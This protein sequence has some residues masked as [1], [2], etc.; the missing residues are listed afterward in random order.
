MIKMKRLIPLALFL[1]TGI[2]L[3]GQCDDLFFSEYVEGYS[4]NKALEI[5]NPT[6]EPINLSEYSIARASNGST[7]P[8]SNQVIGLPDMMIEPND[9]FVVCVDLRDT[10]LWDSQF[11][12]PAWNGYNV[13]DTLFDAVTGEPITDEDGNV[14]FGPQYTE[15]GE[16]LFGDEY[17]EEYDLQCK[18]DAFL[19]PDYDQNNT[20]YF[21]GNDAMIL[22]KG[23][24]ISSSG[25]NIIDVIGVIGEDPEDTINEDAWVNED[26][27]WL[28]KNRTLVRKPEITTGRNVLADVVYAL[29]G[30]F[31]GQE[32]ESYRNNTF[33]YLGIHNSVC[34][35]EAKP[36]RY[37]CSQGPL[38]SAYNIAQLDFKVFPNP[39]RS[40]YINISAE[41]PFA[42]VELLDVLGH[43][44][45]ELRLSSDA[46]RAEMNLGSFQKG[47]YIVRII[48][49]DNN[50]AARKL[51]IE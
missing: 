13:I 46:Q 39:A 4:N 37:S 34:N 17:T 31:D 16:A 43:R 30:T 1:M 33:D 35:N 18:A 41:E 29:G 40:G 20:M 36:D 44:V 50:W 26:G 49:G 19:C 2:M 28:T 22:L 3:N 42:K 7:A 12:K 21:N 15:N 25:D 47:I 27:F 24:A 51:I 6:D 38:S 45:G 32:W 5:Y 14:I 48:D 10:S 11:D 8:A 9:V 23:D